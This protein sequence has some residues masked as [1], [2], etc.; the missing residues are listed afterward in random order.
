M[1]LHICYPYPIEARIL[2][3]F[4][5]NEIRSID[6]PLS[7]VPLKYTFPSMHMCQ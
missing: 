4:Y 2:L 1:H 6:T 3:F 5:P 7:L